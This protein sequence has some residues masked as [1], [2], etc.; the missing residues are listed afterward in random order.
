MIKIPL[1]YKIPKQGRPNKSVSNCEECDFSARHAYIIPY[2]IG[3]FEY[4]GMQFVAW[5]CP[6]CGS[7]WYFHIRTD[8]WFKWY[9]EYLNDYKI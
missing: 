1:K 8:A 7:K 5:E 2:I 3:F 9:E 6:E 4:A